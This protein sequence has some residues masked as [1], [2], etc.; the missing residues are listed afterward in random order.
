MSE[1]ASPSEFAPPPTLDIQSLTMTQIIRLQNQLQ[2]E[3]TRRFERPMLL[4]FSDIVGSTPYIA[5]YGD[6]LGRQLQQLHFDLLELSLPPAQG[7]IVDTA[8][9]GA[10]CVFPGADAAIQGVIAFQ[11]ALAHE[12]AAR[13]HAHQLRVRVGL[14]WGA[15]LTD[16]VVVS[17]DA[18][19]VCARVAA[20][21]APGTIRL[22]RQVFHELGPL[23]RLDC[24]LV[25]SVELKGL[26]G[27]IE[28]FELDWRDTASFPR[29]LR[30]VETE[31]DVALP[32]QDIVSLGR[33]LEH[34]GARANDIVLTHPDPDKSRQI[35]RWH[36]ELRR[37]ADGLRLRVLSDSGTEVDGR[38]V[39]R[40]AETPVRA[41]S[42]IRVADV[43]TLV[44]AGAEG[45]GADD[46]ANRTMVRAVPARPPRG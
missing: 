35:S 11:K 41:G 34:D 28:L 32:Q 7:R 37:V 26:G 3:L 12:N 29:R 6:A 9:D 25:G 5:R 21:A 46:D 43:L 30:I 27:A 42:Q 17:G 44:L 14:H 19:N 22:T 2:H 31:V 4:L 40:G 16:G 45:F 8:G 13:S 33:L 24:R 18:V 23:Q 1:R 20:S 38:P 15:V 36:L 39:A 10:F